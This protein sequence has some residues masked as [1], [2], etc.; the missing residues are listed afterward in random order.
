MKKNSTEKLLTSHLYTYPEAEL[1]DIFK[2]LHQSAFGCEH[3]ISSPDNVV[4][5]IREEYDT[6]SEERND[7]IEKLDGRYCRV[8]LSYL[9]KGLS[10]KTLAVLLYMSS[11]KEKKG[12]IRLEE[13]LN[14]T[15]ELIKKKILP[16]PEEE[17][18]AALRKW[19]AD[20]YPP[21]HHSEHFRNTYK[22]YYRV[23]SDS[24]IPFLPILSKIDS[25]SDKLTR[26]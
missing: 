20:N 11:K 19:Q 4:L 7:R 3:I 15:R 8:P 5:R 21:I 6:L 14:I 2:F 18:E 22:P 16:Y 1:Q 23:I 12:K 13:K 24:F 26:H 9:K 17:F 10:A 25:L